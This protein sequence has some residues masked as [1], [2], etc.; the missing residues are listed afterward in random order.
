MILLL[1]DM[2]IQR[3]NYGEILSVEFHAYWFM[4]KIIQY[5]HKH[6]SFLKIIKANTILYKILTGKSHKR[7]HYKLT[8][9]WVY[10]L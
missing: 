7:G 1:H 6:N 9:K 10:F 4:I 5:I 8:N 2:L 3:N